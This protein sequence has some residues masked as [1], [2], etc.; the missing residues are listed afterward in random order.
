MRHGPRKA[1]PACTCGF[2]RGTHGLFRTTGRSHF[3]RSG[4]LSNMTD[5]PLAA[6]HHAVKKDVE[7][8]AL[9]ATTRLRVFAEAWRWVGRSL[10]IAHATL[11]SNPWSPDRV[12][13]SL[14]SCRNA[15][16][17]TAGYLKRR[18]KDEGGRPRGNATKHL[19]PG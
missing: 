5:G 6:E 12:C 18:V 14:P 1:L 15:L 19:G 3:A 16:C 10:R 9:G 11:D 17:R 8:L 7:L 2:A 13:L 4:S